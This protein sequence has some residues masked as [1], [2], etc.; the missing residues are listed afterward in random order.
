[1]CGRLCNIR[2]RDNLMMQGALSVGT[3]HDFV[4]GDKLMAYNAGAMPPNERASFEK[5]IEDAKINLLRTVT[6]NA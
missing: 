3:W 2:D 6:E 4:D 1:M 5:D